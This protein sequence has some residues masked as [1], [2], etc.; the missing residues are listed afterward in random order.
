MA[1]LSIIGTSELD[2]N[3]AS[4]A[5]D[6]MQQ[7]F[8]M[9]RKSFERRWYDNNFFDDGHHFRYVSRITGK[10][11]DVNDH[12]GLYDPKRA[13]PKSSRQIRGVA[14]LL[15]QSD[16]IPVVYPD[17]IAPPNEDLYK[18]SMDIA[19]KIGSWITKE[20]KDQE[21]VDKLVQMV[22]LAAKNSISYLQV[23]PDE[24]KQ[25]IQSKVY[26]AFDIY[27]QGSLTDIYDSPTIIK[28][29]PM[30]IN[31]IKN[32]DHFDE[33][34]RGKLNAD[35]KYASSEIKEAYMRARFGF[36][37]AAN[38]SAATVLFKEAYVKEY[39]DQNNLQ[40]IQHQDN[41]GDILDGKKMGDC[42]IRQVMS[43]AG[44]WLKDVYTDLPE[45]P[46]IDFRFEPGPIYQTSLIER[47]I[48]ANKSLDTLMS[49]L[50]K[51]ANTMVTGVWSKRKGES[52]DITNIAGAQVVEYETT[53]PQ[54]QLIANIPPFYFEAIGLL[55]QFIDEQ[56][57]ATSAL[58][59]IPKGVKANS[60]IESLKET[61]YA[62]LKIATNQI[63]KV[64]RRTTERMMDIADRY[65]IDPQ[66]VKIMNDGNPVQFQVIGNHGKQ[67][68]ESA[69]ISTD[70][71]I[72]I[73]KDYKVDIEVESGAAYTYEGKKELING[74]IDKLTVL[75][76]A[77]Y[78]SQEA[79]KLVVKKMI[80]IYKLGSTAE[81]MQ[82]MDQV[83]NDTTD[84]DLAKMKIA[85][86][87]VMKDLDLAGPKASDQRIMEN[88]IGTVEGLK[89]AG[90][91]D[92]QPAPNKVSESIS[93]KDAPPDVK[94]Q[95][96]IQ[97]G[98]QPSTMPE[99]QKMPDPTKIVKTAPKKGKK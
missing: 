97:A 17:T 27:L 48:P 71:L 67:L 42:V 87:E 10:I 39:L 89:D 59:V 41:A 55:N 53:P 38:D 66:E 63:K 79:V 56:G 8:S 70:G 3:A 81:F 46:F 37:T 45:Y 51:Y 12:V 23:W 60:A 76:Q 91:V 5:V 94:R 18:I 84:M 72:P 47:F 92:K 65:F 69:E 74:L 50:E 20:W 15:A 90:L 33:E 2:S 30:L 7:L 34:Q 24:Y 54:Q 96:E 19:K 21:L 61:E 83:P 82:A 22:I 32:D 29:V 44:V 14:N 16:Y 78:V 13:I 31:Q 73:S 86:A 11:V 98:L 43:A 1:N 26:D 95:I 49:R 77:G 57:V 75:A 52:F 25:K 88:K 36:N 58:N 99:A 80:E 85:I 28:C 93:Y 9:Q 35:N 6:R 62:N 68:M 4:M 40:V 64:I